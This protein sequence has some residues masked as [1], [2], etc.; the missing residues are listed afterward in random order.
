MI[1]KLYT[2]DNDIIHQVSKLSH[3]NDEQTIEKEKLYKDNDIIHQVSKL[4]HDYN[5]Q[6]INLIHQVLNL[7][8]DDEQIIN[9]MI[10]YMKDLNTKRDNFNSVKA[11]GTYTD[12]D[13]VTFNDGVS[14][15]AEDIKNLLIQHYI[16]PVIKK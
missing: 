4:S 2:K 13:S 10:S 11:M 3:D 12:K 9:S 14:K 15:R 7:S 5:K 1:K 16:V 8:H 6:I